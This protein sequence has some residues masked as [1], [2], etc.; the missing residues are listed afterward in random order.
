MEWVAVFLC[1]SCL[2]HGRVGRVEH[3]CRSARPTRPWHET[4][5]LLNAFHFLRF[6]GA[7]LADSVLLISQDTQVATLVRN[8]CASLNAAFSLARSLD[9]VAGLL[10]ADEVDLVICDYTTFEALRARWPRACVV[11]YS[12]PKD[13]EQAIEAIKL[14]ALDYLPN[15]VTPDIVTAQIRGALRIRHD[16]KVP[17]IYESRDE[18]AEVDRIIG[19][20]P[21]MKELYKLIGLIAPRDINVLITGESGTGK[22]MVARAILHHSA[23][24]SRPF[25]AINCA[26]IPDTLLESELFGHEKG[27][28]TGADTRRIGKFEQCQGGTLFLDEV[29]D[30]PLGTQVKL[31]R[32]LQDNAFQRLGGAEVIKCDVRIIAA[33]HQALD[34]LIE[35]RRFREDLYHRLMVADIHVPPLR[36]REVDAVLL[37]HYYMAR[38]NRQFGTSVLTIAPEV[39]PVLIEYPWPGNVRELE[40]AVKSALVLARGSILRL[41][42]LPAKIQ[43]HVPKGTSRPT[44]SPDT[45]GPSGPLG[46]TESPAHSLRGVVANLMNDKSLDGALHRAAVSMMERE[47]IIACLTRSQGRAAAAAKQLGISRTTLRKRIA[48]LGITI[49]ATAT[50]R[51]AGE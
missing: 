5:A 21:V 4:D 36:E 1:G 28:F 12:E 31:L 40:N 33:T 7:T 20:S 22:E 45:P 17:A 18:T 42:H 32:A 47:L 13:S 35:E 44:A 34:R 6:E 15:L 48:E 8:A 50:G 26:A 10:D 24:R 23:R 3:P 51:V 38:Y 37:A 43:A 41:E 30:I 27:A 9:D 16:I 14:G 11:L 39:L 2:C 19:E 25:L 46:S 29:G 49:S